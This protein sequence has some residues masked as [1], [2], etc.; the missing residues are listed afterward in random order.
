MSKWWSSSSRP[1]LFERNNVQLGPE[2]DGHTIP[3]L[4]TAVEHSAAKQKEFDLAEVAA[5]P[6]GE[7]IA[8]F[9]KR[10][11]LGSLVSNGFH[12]GIS[13]N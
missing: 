3:H 1:A 4:E 8:L 9:A 2:R 13:I 7:S 6:S 11:L 12:Y 10:Q 5:A